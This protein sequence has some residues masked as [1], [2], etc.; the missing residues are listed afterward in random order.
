MNQYYDDLSYQKLSE[1][2]VFDG[3]RIKVDR[4]K[5][6]ANGKEIIREIVKAGQAVVILPVKENGNVIMI[7]EE[8]PAIGKKVL[9]LP[10]GMIEEGED[11]K[12]AAFRELEEET[13]YQAKNLEFLRSLYASCGYSDEKIYYYL[14]TDFTKTQQHLD[15]DEFIDVIEVPMKELEQMLDNNEILTGSVTIALMDY[16]R[17]Q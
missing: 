8:R 6:M 7:Q 4:E 3:I 2:R 14:A 12:E 10:A 9:G 15:Q 5:Y 13:G 1:E 11:P 17:R 16:L